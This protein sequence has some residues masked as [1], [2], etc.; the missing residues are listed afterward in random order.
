M[1]KAVGADTV[2]KLVADIPAALR[3]GLHGIPR[4]LS[5]C[6]L[7]ADLRE[8]ASRN[9]D[10]DGFTSY[11]GA[12]AYEHYIP[13][14]LSHIVGRSE[15]YTAYTPYQPEASQ[16]TLQAVYE[17]QSVMCGLTAMDVTNASLYDGG[18]AVA[19][20]ALM[21]LAAREGRSEV[22]VSELVHPE[23][24]QVLR[25][26]LAQRKVT[27]REIP[28][29]DG[30]TDL[31]TLKGRVSG[32]TAAVII[33]SPNFFGSLEDMRA[34]E[35]IIH[36]AGALFVAV[37]NPLSLGVI[38]PPGEYNADIAVGE[39]Q[40]LGNPV[41]FGGP[42]LGFIAVKDELKRR[43]PGRMVGVTLDRNGKKGFVLTLQAREQ[44]IRREKATSNIC[45]N[46]ALCALSACVYVSLLGKQG[47]VE[48]AKLNIARSHY[49]AS[50][51]AAVEGIRVA[52]KAPFFNEFVV[53]S[54]V[55]LK[56][57]NRYLLRNKVIA[58][59][60]ISRFYKGCKNMMLVCATETKSP[61]DLD[62]YAEL[63]AEVAAGAAKVKEPVCEETVKGV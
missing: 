62:R 13:S 4:P 48:L 34:C 30:A 43:M 1:L 60:D 38:A 33:Q 28:H 42:Y 40:P 11:L 51:I 16:G 54:D 3:H 50:K 37:V 53:E 24:R 19:E 59:L 41:A 8:R 45:S 32:N 12:G 52:F 49:L 14:A 25:T 39:G 23:Y 27:I 6:E 46:E 18:S 9:A 15:F 61:D 31:K 22:I 47:M 63:L 5:E 10:S 7:L 57:I 35:E 44:H 20:A 2:E 26:Y 56:K 36:K 21:A 17:Y 29:V 55:P 58:G